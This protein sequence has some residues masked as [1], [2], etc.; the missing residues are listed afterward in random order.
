MDSFLN[1]IKRILHLPN[2]QKID[3]GQLQSDLDRKLVFSLSKSRIPNLTQLKYIKKYLSIKEVWYLRVSFLVIIFSLVFAGVNFYRNN[4]QIV[5]ARGGVYT[6]GLIGSPKHI[7]P[8]YANLNDVDN[9]ISLLIFSSLFK[10]GKNG[11]L[12]NDLVTD[13]QISEDGKVYNL[14][15]RDDVK[16]HIKAS[17]E[18]TLTSDD[19][20][21][22]FN[23]IL[24]KQYNSPLRFSFSGV[25]VEKIDDTNL[26]FVLSDPYGAFLELLTFGIMPADLWAEIPPESVPL[27]KLNLNPIGSGPYIFDNLVKEESGVVREYTLKVNEDYYGDKP[28]LDIKFKFF[29]NFEE[30]ISAL[31]NAAVDGISYLP[32]EYK[33]SIL[34]PKTFNFNKLFLPQLTL[35]Y[36]NKEE[37]SALGDKSVRQALS[38][39][40]NK[41]EVVN[42]ILEGDAYI[43]DSPILPN[44]FAYNPD[45]KKYDY[46]IQTAKEMLDK[47]DWKTVSISQDDIKKAQ[48]D[49]G[50]DDEKIKQQAET[51]I[52]LGVGEWRKKDN[53]YLIVNLKTVERQ[54]NRKIIEAIKSYWEAVGVKTEIEILTSA[55]IQT[56]IVKPRKFEALFYGQVLGTD[57]DPY[58]FWHSSQIGENGFN[59]A[60]FA[61][62]DVDQLLEDARLI[63][64]KELRK[65]KYKEFQS[66]IIEEFPVIF[67]YSPT[68]TYV[69][70][71]KLKGFDVR[72]ISLPHDRFANISEWY[73]KT[74]KQLIW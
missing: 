57:P 29:P 38:Y 46:N 32:K 73:N 10:R 22:T 56:D 52:R 48:E 7:N 18:R 20:I 2:V 42:N 44:S 36:L 66:V 47:T 19:V 59:I 45:I 74:K 39:A 30:A 26:K 1:K 4:L 9:D 12:V 13:Y 70:S 62:K 67:M 3:N 51:T 55:A 61:D 14:T 54:E 71:A 34:T 65:E 58:A 41:N 64:D 11:E 43:V 50:S 35:I 49:L 5:P 17:L 40:I 6:E 28:Y 69:Q 25:S 24:N 15:I 63:S 23:T 21:F 60:N 27:A 16:W 53:N 31:N 72:N 37:N 33:S 8:L 68:Y